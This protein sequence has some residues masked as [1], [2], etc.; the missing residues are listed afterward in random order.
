MGTRVAAGAFALMASGS[1]VAACGAS[2]G[3]LAQA[4]CKH[5]NASI[6]LLAKASR[7]AN[8]EQA[9]ALRYQAYVQLLDAIPIAAQAAYHDIQWESLS[10]TLAESNRVPESTLIPALQAQCRN[11]N[12]SVFNQV[13]PSSSSGNSG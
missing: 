13:P 1:V 8:S 7:T 9:A 6:G 5:I 3:D 11:L 10:M 2:A 4:S 12:T